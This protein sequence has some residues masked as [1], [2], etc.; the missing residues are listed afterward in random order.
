[1]T[2]TPFRTASAHSQSTSAELALLFQQSP[3]VM[4]ILDPRGTFTNLNPA[5]EHLFARPTAELIGQPFETVLDPFSHAKARLMLERTF[6]DGAVYDW[7]LDHLQPNAP[8]ILIG[9]TTSVLRSDSGAILGLAAIGRDLTRTLDLTAQLAESNQQ[10]EG[11]LLQ[12][13][14]VHAALKATQTQLVQSEKM[15]TLGQLVAGVAHE[16][17][18]PLAFTANNLA[19]LAGLVPALQR[20]FDTYVLLKP[21]ADA[22]QRAAIAQ[23]ESAAHID[24]LWEDLR[25]LVAESQRGVERISEIVLSLRNFARLDEAEMKAI[26]INEGLSSTVRIVRPLCKER[27]EISENYAD[28][29][30]LVCHPSELNQ[31]FLNLLTNAMQ[32]IAGHGQIWISSAYRDDQIIVSVRDTGVGMDAATL[33]HLGEPFFTT[34]PIGAGSGLGLAVSFGIVERHHGQLRFDSAPGVGTTVTVTLPVQS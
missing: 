18:T 3:L 22:E 29:P 32:A 7:E 20:L 8:P 17:N 4:L 24:Y 28:L 34:K 19:H 11:A 25:D 30:P 12:L 26:D 14:K 6:A 15:R 9:Y 33:A 13:E 10:L 16:I 21:F 1:M 31:V 2:E 27:I 23:A 5:A